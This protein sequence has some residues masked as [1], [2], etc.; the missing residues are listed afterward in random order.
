VHQSALGTT[1]DRELKY[2]H[3]KLLG[4]R[5]VQASGVPYTILRPSLLFGDG[6]EFMVT[7][8][9]LVRAFPVVPVPG[10][11]KTLF[12]PLAVEDCARCLALCL[13]E[14]RHVGQTYEI[15]GPERLSYDEII[16]LI[17]RVLRTRRKL[18]HVPLPLM[19]PLVG[20]MDALLPRPP[21]TPEQLKNLRI[22][23]VTDIESIPRIFGFQPLAPSR[24]LE[25][26]RK[27]TRADGIKMALGRM[28]AHLRDH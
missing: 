17:A 16:R 9:G 10:D 27:V 22:D 8:A 12:Q 11:G 15:G 24:D 3:S 13:Q 20:L 25:Y 26:L 28:P 14:P 6:D 23:N 1:E 7:L 4:E 2:S 21:A 18:L 5:Q 19:R